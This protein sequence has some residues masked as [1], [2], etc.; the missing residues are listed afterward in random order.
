MLRNAMLAAISFAVL[1]VI[2]GLGGSAWAA[3]GTVSLFGSSYTGEHYS[4]ELASD[5]RTSYGITDYNF[6]RYDFGLAT[7]NDMMNDL[8]SHV[9]EINGTVLWVAMFTDDDAP[10]SSLGFSNVKGVE[11]I[12]KQLDNYYHRY[13]KI[14]SGGTGYDLITAYNDEIVGGF[15]CNTSTLLQAVTFGG[16]LTDKSTTYLLRWAGVGE[17]GDPND[18][19]DRDVTD[20]VVQNVPT[21][22]VYSSMIRVPEGEE[23][24][25]NDDGCSNSISTCPVNS[26]GVGCDI[27]TNKC[28][29]GADSS[30]CVV[31]RMDASGAYVPNYELLRDFRDRMF[32]YGMYSY[33]A[34]YELF[35]WYVV[36]GTSHAAAMPEIETAANIVMNGTA[37]QVVLT[38]SLKTKLDS[39]IDAAEGQNAILDQ[40]LAT[41]QAKLTATVGMTRS[42]FCAYMVNDSDCMP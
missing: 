38:S 1:F 27:V 8:E 4:T 30:S 31:A 40:G 29:S 11:I 22:V 42:Q 28:D 3:T 36:P 6:E 26:R 33:V 13:Y 2:L 5:L 16:S 14:N 12:F 39:I 34:T 20:L 25:E 18:P 19:F 10:G 23:G 24:G 7:W 37:N 32:D 35:S 21:T 17:L 9:G 15:M 41:I